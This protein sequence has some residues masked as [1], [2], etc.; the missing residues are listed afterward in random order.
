MAENRGREEFTG[1][2]GA[3]GYAVL[4]REI[5]AGGRFTLWGSGD[6]HGPRH[7]SAGKATP[8]GSAV[9]P[10]VAERAARAGSGATPRPEGLVRLSN[11][12]GFTPSSQPH[13]G[14]SRTRDPLREGP[15]APPRAGRIDRS[16]HLRF[17]TESR[18]ETADPPQRGDHGKCVVH[19]G[20]TLRIANPVG[21]T[22][23]S[24]VEGS[25]F[26]SHVGFHDPPEHAMQVGYVSMAGTTPQATRA[27]PPPSGAGVSE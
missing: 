21:S 19:P 6:S 8:C 9:R 10:P 11:E 23:L 12:C 17:G 26:R 5:D 27:P 4:E 20:D 14:R 7:S 18:M 3:P 2:V 22:A 16:G 25:P 1:T 24:G 13:R 15:C